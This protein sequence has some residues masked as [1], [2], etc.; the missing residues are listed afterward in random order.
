M[1]KI[2]TTLEKSKT[3]DEHRVRLKLMEKIDLRRVAIV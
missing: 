1:I 3:S 2:F